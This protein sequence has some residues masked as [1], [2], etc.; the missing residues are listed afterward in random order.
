M[1]LIPVTYS[2]SSS[3][4]R[5]DLLAPS[6]RELH[7]LNSRFRTHHGIWILAE[8]LEERS[9][10]RRAELPEKLN[11]LQSH[12]LVFARHSRFGNSCGLRDLASEIGLENVDL[13]VRRK[14][15]KLLLRALHPLQ[16]RVGE[17]L[18]IERQCRCKVERKRQSR[19][20]LLDPFK[21]RVRSRR[22]VTRGKTRPG[23]RPSI[24]RIQR[25][26][27]AVLH[28]VQHRACERLQVWIRGVERAVQDP[29]VGESLVCTS[30]H[31][32]QSRMPKGLRKL[33][34]SRKLYSWR[35]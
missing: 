35:L 7:Q 34:C 3:V 31:F 11:R 9:R 8:L 13:F 16:Q 29:H 24:E 15:V 14:T 18:S 19:F 27:R 22:E 23:P 5:M 26:L 4:R 25:I 33:V 21:R 28:T 6:N 17:S 2:H 20:D 12:F 30:I 1:D 10:F 32:A